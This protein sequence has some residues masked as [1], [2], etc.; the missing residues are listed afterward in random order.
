MAMRTLRTICVLAAMLSLGSCQV[1]AVVF[2]SVFPSTTTLLKAQADLSG[3]IPSDSGGSFHV[4]VVESQGYG[5]VV[6]VGNPQSGSEAFFY[7]LDL[8]QKATFT[9]GLAGD[10]MMVDASG[11]IVLGSLLLN[12]ANLKIVGTTNAANLNSPNGG[13]V[14]GFVDTLANV[15]ITAFGI[16]S[17]N[18]LNYASFTTAWTFISSHITTLSSSLSNLQIDAILDD[19][20]P[21]GNVTFVVGPQANNNT[22]RCYFFSTAKS[23]F[24]VATNVLDSSPLYRDNLYTN[25]FGY[26]QGSIFAYDSGSG[27]FVRIDPSTGSTQNSYYDASASSNSCFA[28]RTSGGSFYGFDTNTRV[29]KKYGQWW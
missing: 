20:N 11:N 10:A 21:S 15:Q 27:S 12:P 6:V 26:A 3:L 4:R 19:G 24:T 16:N 18:T 29:L 23:N 2:G 14:D 25:S 9:S 1:L 7:D 8:N 28:Y 5:Y 22:A 17:S 13:G